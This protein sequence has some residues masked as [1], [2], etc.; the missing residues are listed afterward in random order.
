MGVVHWPLRRRHSGK[1]RAVPARPPVDPNHS[2]SRRVQRGRGTHARQ[3]LESAR[4]KRAK[5]EIGYLSIDGSRSAAASCPSRPA[6]GRTKGAHRSP[7]LNSS[8]HVSR[9]PSVAGGEVNASS[10][11]RKSPQIC[12]PCFRPKG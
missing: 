12:L 3:L 1:G 10:T 6:H 8:T 9:V 2:S 7:A 11:R 5:G 4:E